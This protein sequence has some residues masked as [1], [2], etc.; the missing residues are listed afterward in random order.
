MS[1]FPN[2]DGASTINSAGVDW[3]TIT[4]GEAV[5]ERP[6]MRWG[7]ALI[8]AEDYGKTKRP[9]RQMG[10]VGWQGDHTKVGVRNGNESIVMV[11]GAVAKEFASDVPLGGY[12]VTRFDVE[13][14][15]SL[16]K[17]VRNLALKEYRSMQILNQQRAKE[18]HLKF[19]SSNTGDTLYVGKRTSSVVLRVYDK[20]FTF[21]PNELGLYWRYE[22]E[23]K[24]GAAQP[25]YDAWVEAPSKFTHSVGTVATEFSKRGLEPGFPLDVKVNAIQAKA[26][27]STPRGQ[28]VWLE[29][30]VAPVVAQ[31]V[32][33]GHTEEVV[34]CLRLNNL[35]SV[36]E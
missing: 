24:K 30:C 4:T 13:V 21:R 19:I 28:L 34:K 8:E 11:S 31:L 25:A 26:K 15:L 20:T 27:L 33:N 12:R 14:T 9:W 16:S 2:D 18:R 10:Y 22:V 36:K 35:F 7:L 6:L 3:I 5:D 17:P 1:V 23:F 32:Y 29:K